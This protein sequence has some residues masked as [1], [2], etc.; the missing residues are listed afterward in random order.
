MKKLIKKFQ[1]P[2]GTIQPYDAIW[3]KEAKEKEAKE[4]KEY[5]QYISQ[6][7]FKTHKPIS[8]EQWKKRKSKQLK[9]SGEIKQGSTNNKVVNGI[10]Q[11]FRELKYD[12]SQGNIPKGKYML[13]AATLATL[14]ISNI[15][16]L[17]GSFILG[18]IGASAVDKISNI[19]TGN[20]WA[21]N[22]QNLTGL[23]IT[24]A[25]M[26][27]PGG[28]LGGVKGFKVAN[29]YTGQVKGRYQFAN[30]KLAKYE[31]V[32]NAVEDFGYKKIDKDYGYFGYWSGEPK[33]TI[34]GN[35]VQKDGGVV[36]S[37]GFP[38]TEIHLNPRFIG[39]MTSR[40]VI[41]H[42][43]QPG[44]GIQAVKLIKAL[45]KS[46]ALTSSNE[47]V[48]IQTIIS[49]APYV[50]RLNYYLTGST[51]KVY[52][53]HNIEGYSTDIMELFNNKK[54]GEVTPSLTTRLDGTNT[55]GKTWGKYKKY[56]G[57]PKDNYVKFSDMTPE[58]VQAWNTE[59]AP[60]I[61]HYIDPDN[62]TSQQLILITK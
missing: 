47:A 58:Q 60:K 18:S 17:F 34:I 40:T 33:R 49:K 21:Q 62:R 32:I 4:D 3:V 41:D 20:T 5:Q 29:N 30:K 9:G 7:Y 27:N 43:P 12:L 1:S 38:T 31:D 55:Y 2:S 26:S 56:F 24:P 51:P 11:Y 6:P 57:T 36:L 50:T 61:G 25:E 45:P 19:L 16:G 48:P 52:Y 13:P 35:L 42:S 8:K 39:D 37:P 59:V 28:L 23:D 14:S 54:L 22:V 46:T 10:N 53:S 44:L 15:P